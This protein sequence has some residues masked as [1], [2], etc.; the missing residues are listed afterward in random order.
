MDI[1]VLLGLLLALISFYFGVPNLRSELFLYFQLDSLFLV[2][3]GTIASTM[4]ST[5]V[6]QFRSILTVFGYLV[7]RRKRLEPRQ[8]VEI[9]VRIS[10]K[11]QSSNRQA[12]STEARG[13]DDGFL[14]RALSLVGDGLDRDFIKQ[15]LETDIS[16]IER[17]HTQVSNMVRT[18]GNFAPMFGMI[19]TVLGVT[20]VLQN[21]TD[22]ENIV[23]GMSLALLTTLY[24]LIL[25]TLLFIPSANKLK[26]MT[27]RE[28]LTKEII[29]E[30]VLMIFDKEIPLKVEKYLMAYLASKFKKSEE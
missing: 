7:F 16:E 15:T 4:I 9:L 23:A 29:T 28:V 10:E 21:V 8:A 25:S 12:L 20:K 2:L 13:V 6:K 19:G 14:Y 24:G 30:G 3:G 27:A 17:R 5:S 1:M 18:M 11:A 26:G 22:V